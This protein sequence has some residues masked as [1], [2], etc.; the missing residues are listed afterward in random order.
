MIK[1]PIMEGVDRKVCPCGFKYDKDGQCT[2]PSG[3]LFPDRI[4]IHKLAQ[5]KTDDKPGDNRRGRGR[6]KA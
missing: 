1:L 6:K 4:T 2:R 5:E 3:P